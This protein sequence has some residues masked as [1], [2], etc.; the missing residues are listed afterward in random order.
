MDT[1]ASPDTPIELDRLVG[2]VGDV[3]FVIGP[4]GIIVA[5]NEKAARD[6]GYEHSSFVGMDA[7][8]LFPAASAWL[9]DSA[10]GVWAASGDFFDVEQCRSNGS[11]FIAEF[12]ARDLSDAGRPG[13]VVLTMREVTELTEC[14]SELELKSLM[15]EGSLDAIIAH[16]AGGELVYFNQAAADLMGLSIDDFAKLPNYGWVGPKDRADLPDQLIRLRESGQ[17]RFNSSTIRPDGKVIL[18]EVHARL[19]DTSRGDLIIESLRDITDRVAAQERM[20]HLAFHDSLTGLPNRAFADR[21]LR[22]ATSEATRRGS[23]VGVVFVDLDDFKPINDTYG[24][25]VGDEVLRI[26]AGR[27][28]ECVRE[29]D[30]VARLGGDEFLVMLPHL[31]R[32]EDLAVVALKLARAVSEPIAVD[33]IETNVSAS[34]GL[35]VY[36]PGEALDE[37]IRRADAEMYR[38][39]QQRL[40]G[41]EV[42]LGE[43]HTG[44]ATKA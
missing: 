24:H 29:Y 1:L 5:A 35:A 6:Y 25:G 26:L 17:S 19:V 20:T 31:D 34:V 43:S 2:F 36:E 22:N 16:E 9:F 30:L 12:C 18:T 33:D 11:T 44:A 15:L 38:A 27:M 21:R 4:G 14:Q 40:P 8:E 32:R 13:Y 41:W 3:C 10:L 39:K 42:F 23:M 37:L 7:R 28:K